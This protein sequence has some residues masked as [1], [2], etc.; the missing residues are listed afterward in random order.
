MEDLKSLEEKF[1]RAKYEYYI[2]GVPT[3]L[4]SDFDKLEK[5]LRDLGSNITDLVDFPSIEELE[6]LGFDIDKIAPISVVKNTGIKTKHWTSMLSIQKLQANDPKNLPYHDLDLFLSRKKTSS[7]EVGL[8]FDGNSISLSYNNFKL[9]T[10]LTRGDGIKGIDKT[11]KLKLI[12]PN[13]ISLDGRFEI[14]GEVVISKELFRKKYADPSKVQNER[15][16][17]AGYLSDEDVDIRIIND[18]TFIAYSIVKIKSDGTQ[19]YIVESMKILE[20]LGFNKKYK[21]II[22]YMSSSKDFD[23]IYNDFKKYKEDCPFLIDGIVIKYPE[24]LRL[25]MGD[26]GHYWKWCLAIKFQSEEVSTRIISIEW[27]LGKDSYLTPVAILDPVVL[28]DTTV[29]R[30]S[31]SNLG[32]LVNKGAFPGAVISLK[33]SGDIIPMLTSVLEK[34]KDHE[35]YMK[36]FNDI[37]KL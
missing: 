8:K 34:S 18:L 30:C 14:R 27:R 24:E 31:L 7:Y 15:N 29:T 22:E 5:K 19:E 32:V 13:T 4:D 11:H 21:P 35:L 25:S 10:A 20:S 17:V 9:E 26:N 37:K 3:M 36:E 28:L 6:K 23:R 2:L 12:V 1:L 33:K 16:V